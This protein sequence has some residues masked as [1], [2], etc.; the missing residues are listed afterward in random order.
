MQPLASADNSHSETNTNL[1]TTISFSVLDENGNDISVHT[2]LDQPIELIIPRDPNVIIP[3][4]NLQNV[5]TITKHN[6]SFYLHYN[7]LTRKNNLT[8]SFH[9]EIHPLNTSL[10]YLFIYNFDRAPSLNQSIDR[11]DG[12][13]LFCPS[14]KFFS[15][16]EM[17]YFL[18]I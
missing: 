17:I 9:L 12:W 8:I 6:Q 10:A 13:T 15:S 4:M 5:T 16:L 2:N 18:L 1:S 14:S 11:M 3:L 7:N